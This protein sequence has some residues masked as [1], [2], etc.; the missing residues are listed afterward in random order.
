VLAATTAPGKTEAAFLPILTEIADE[1]SDGFH[2]LYVGPLRALINDQFFRLE[3][4]C[5]ILKVPVAK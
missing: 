5:E 2:V 4:L 1:H 3:E